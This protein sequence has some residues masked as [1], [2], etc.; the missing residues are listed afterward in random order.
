MPINVLR[1][2]KGRRY[3]QFEFSRRIQGERVRI[4]ES[5][6]VAW[7]RAQADEYDRKRA[8]ELY[9]VATGL[10]KPQHTIEDAVARYL[11]ERAPELKHGAAQARD[12]DLMRPWFTGRRIED[13]P[14]VC[15]DYLR[16]NRAQLAPA[17]IKNRMR[18]LVSACRWCWKHPPKFCEHD[19][20]AGVVYPAVKNERDVWIDRAQ[21]VM[22]AKACE[23]RAVRA[24]IRIAFYSGMRQGEIRRASVAGDFFVLPDSKNG[25]PVRIPIHPKVRACTGYEWP[26][27]YTIG[28]HFRKARAKLSL[29]HVRFHDERHSTA[30]E[31]L[32]QG[33]DLGTVGAVLR[34]KSAASTRRYAHYATEL[35]EQAI[36]K[37]GRKA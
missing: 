8:A 36:G 14:Q 26:T 31:L 4:R 29:D 5:L 16:D 9:A 6:P 22:L 25:D 11:T 13:L 35:L 24:M 30:T 2:R 33:E 15:A 1:D 37:I 19:P 20:G 17:T 12:M 3:F 34:H 28:Y 21:M 23:H 32:R 27:R 10:A 7:T 18:Y